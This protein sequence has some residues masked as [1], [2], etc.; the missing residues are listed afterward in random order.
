MGLLIRSTA[1]GISEEALLKDLYFLKK[2][3]NFIQQ[4]A[5]SSSLPCLLY[6][7]EDLI[8][9][10]VRD[11]YH[12]TIDIV[13]SDSEYSLRQFSYYLNQWSCKSIKKIRL[14]LYCQ[15]ESIFYKFNISTA[16]IDALKTKVHLDIGGYLFIETYE[17]LTVIDVN[18]GSFSKADSSKEIVLRTNC[19]AATEI[20]YQLRIRNLNGVV[21]VDFIDMESHR[22]QLQ[23]LEHF[24]RALSFDTAKPQI[25]QISKLGLVELTRRRRGQSLFEFFHDTKNK[26]LV[27]FFDRSLTK[28][29]QSMVLVHKSITTLF[30]S[31]FFHKTIQIV[32]RFN[33]YETNYMVTDSDTLSFSSFCGVHQ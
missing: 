14:Q 20:A 10:I 27:H 8:K 12:D 22:D 17:A 26:P 16:I 18:S 5:I 11:F 7:D 1:I 25:L 3:W 30:F 24:A 32:R 31:V 33:Y 23:L 6:R 29:S 15:A 4:I 28:P 21:V 2:Q 19:Y 9:K 13:V